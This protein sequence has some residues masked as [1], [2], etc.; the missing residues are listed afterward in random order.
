MAMPPDAFAARIGSDATPR[1]HDMHLPALAA[2]IG[3]GQSLDGV[4]DITPFAQ[5]LHAVD[6]VIGID[7]RLGSNRTE[8]TGDIGHAR[9]DCKK[10]RRDRDAELARDRITGDNRPGHLKPCKSSVL[11]RPAA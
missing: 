8:A 11:Y 4:A 1:V 10:S 3:G 6:A 2:L 7:Q 9:A 5:H